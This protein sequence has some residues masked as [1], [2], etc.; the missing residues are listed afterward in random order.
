MDKDIQST[1]LKLLGYC[2][3]N[4]WAGYDPY[5]ALN[6]KIVSS[7]PFLNFRLFRLSLTQFLKRSPI[8][9]RPLLLV[10]KTQNPKVIGLFLSAFV[11]LFRA[12]VTTG[13]EY[14]PHLAERLIALRSPG[15][16]HLCWGDNFPWQTRTELVPR[17]APSVV[18]TAFAANGLLD[19]FE[20]R[21]DDRYI[22]MALSA[23]EYLLNDLYW[24]SGVSASGF[25]YPLR[26]VHNQV[27]NANL[28][29]AALF[30]RVYKHTGQ[31]KFLAPALGVA[32]YT[33]T[34]QHADG[35]WN[36]GEK[37]TQNWI[38]NFH[39]AFNLSALHTI[40]TTLATSEFDEPLSRGLQFY[41]SHFFLPSGAVRYFHNRTYSIDAH[42]VAQSIIALLDLKD[43]DST[44]V[45]LARS[46]FDWARN[47]MWNEREGFFYYRVLRSC[48]IRTSYMR[49]TQASMFLALT[50][51]YVESTSPSSDLP[52]PVS[53]GVA[54]C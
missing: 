32:R 13:Q 31:E 7:L 42:C 20:L 21:Q 48:T 9:L 16:S 2:R 24:T 37:S 23:A 36:Y 22:N 33:M 30:S 3:A 10:P 15:P 5:D 14:I 26:E 1:T 40:G 52:H 43:L 45:Q 4:D 41:R 11:N 6:S 17:W 35:G 29:G 38:D 54:S 39:T 8:N 49:W 50:K 28:L 25:G 34:R 19:A 44:N 27:H 51:L 47:H 46:V 18:N 53:G 12:G